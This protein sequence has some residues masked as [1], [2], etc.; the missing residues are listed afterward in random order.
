[1]NI[2]NGK[3]QL[4]LRR[5]EKMKFC[6]IEELKIKRKPTEKEKYIDLKIR[7]SI[8][9]MTGPNTGYA[10]N[11]YKKKYPELTKQLNKWWKEEGKT[12]YAKQIK[13]ANKERKKTEEYTRELDM[14][15]IETLREMIK[16]YRKKKIK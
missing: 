13:Q 16:E 15:E 11:S 9:Y 10:L 14:D 4:N 6:L 3:K 2:W 5:N 7:N 8:G 1:M 12:K